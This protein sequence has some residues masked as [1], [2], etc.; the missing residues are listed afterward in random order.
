M[1]A[2]EVPRHVDV[3]A[4]GDGDVVRQEL[5]WDNVEQAYSRATTSVL[6]SHTSK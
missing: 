5:E 4:L 2:R 1:D 3:V 6:L